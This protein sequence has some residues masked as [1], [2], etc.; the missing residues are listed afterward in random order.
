MNRIK[1]IL[2]II[3]FGWEEMDHMEDSDVI[4]DRLKKRGIKEKDLRP[5]DYADEIGLYGEMMKKEW[6]RLGYM[7]QK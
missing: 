2:E 6:E 3:G 5:T 7:A 4:M 1:L